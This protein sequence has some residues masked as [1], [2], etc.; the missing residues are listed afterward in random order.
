MNHFSLVILLFLGSCCFE[1]CS[2]TGSLSI[3]VASGRLAYTYGMQGPAV[4]MD[5][6]DMGLW[7]MVFFGLACA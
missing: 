2:A 6:G 7:W 3:S 1:S 5:T 4:S